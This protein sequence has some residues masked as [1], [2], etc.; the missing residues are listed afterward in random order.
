MSVR[1]PVDIQFQRRKVA[2]L[3]IFYDT[4]LIIP[5]LNDFQVCSAR[6]YH[7]RSVLHFLRNFSLVKIMD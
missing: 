5:R 2:V 1:L 6:S 3:Q 7:E 4:S